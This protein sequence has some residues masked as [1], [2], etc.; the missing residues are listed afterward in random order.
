MNNRLYKDCPTGEECVIPKRNESYIQEPDNVLFKNAMKV[1]INEHLKEMVEVT[2]STQ[3]LRKKKN[4]VKT[5]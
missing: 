4:K 3:N 5:I 2:F 1:T